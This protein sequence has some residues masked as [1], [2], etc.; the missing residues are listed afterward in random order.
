MKILILSYSSLLYSIGL[1][2]KY[3]DMNQYKLKIVVFNNKNIVKFLLY[4]GIKEKDI[5]YYEYQLVHTLHPYKIAKNFIWMKKFYKSNIDNI[6]NEIIYMFNKNECLEIFDLYYRIRKKNEIRYVNFDP[7]INCKKNVSFKKLIYKLYNKL[8]IKVPY[9]VK[10]LGGYLPVIKDSLIKSIGYNREEVD[11][12]KCNFSKNAIII[13]ETDIFKCSYCKR[14][15]YISDSTNIYN[16][17]SKGVDSQVYIKPHPIFNNIYYKVNDKDKIIEDFIPIEFMIND[18][19]VDVV[20]GAM[21]MA[22][23][24]AVKS[25][26]KN[27]ISTIKLYNFIDNEEKNKIITW[28]IEET[29]NKIVMPCSL[30]ELGEIMNNITGGGKQ[31]VNVFN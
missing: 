15:D 5:V 23:I 19:G 7:E 16:Q 24:Y 27:V 18:G 9:D 4:I 6:E 12:I 13:L 20:I 11:T 17:I 3:K 21:S 26:V 29:D 8:Y 1:Y 31:S 28:L 14:P 2:F 22:L 25:G 10:F 30:K